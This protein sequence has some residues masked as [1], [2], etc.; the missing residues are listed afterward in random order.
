MFVILESN[1]YSY[2]INKLQAR[3]V[4]QESVVLGDRQDIIRFL[5]PIF[6]NI[7]ALMMQMN[8]LLPV[9]FVTNVITLHYLS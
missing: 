1:M 2:E 9:G 5:A 8:V 4:F 3:L 6:G 7:C